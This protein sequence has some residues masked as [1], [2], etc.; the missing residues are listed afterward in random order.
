MTRSDTPTCGAAS[1]TPLALEHRLDHVVH[2]TAYL[3]VNPRH[4]DCLVVSTSLWSETRTMGRTARLC[5]RSRPGVDVDAPAP[6]PG[7][8]RKCPLDICA[9]HRDLPA[10]F[11]TSG[12]GTRVSDQ[13]HRARHKFRVYQNTRRASPADLVSASWSSLCAKCRRTDAHTAESQC[14]AH[15]NLVSCEAEI[16]VRVACGPRSDRGCTSEA[17]RAP[18]HRRV[19]A[20][21]HL[22][23]QREGSSPLPI[24]GE[25]Q[26]GVGV[27]DADESLRCRRS[28]AL[29]NH[30]RPDETVGLMAAESI[31]DVEVTRPR[32]RVVSRSIRMS[33]SAGKRSRTFT[34]E[35]LVPMPRRADG[36]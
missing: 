3:I 26:R 6:S 12:E 18:A 34:L 22:G 21:R 4:A 14:P 10:V 23:Q 16:V 11:A 35:A 17:P 13:G 5:L 31:V 7:K 28:H 9:S 2:E 33:R 8:V 24:V 25:V 29:R 30:L 19:R 15:P 1:P 20:P 27:D 36:A 32:D